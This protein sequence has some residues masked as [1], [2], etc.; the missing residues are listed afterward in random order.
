[1]VDRMNADETNQALEVGR[2]LARQLRERVIPEVDTYRIT[3]MAE[4][5]GNE[6]S[7]SLTKDN[8]Y[9]KIIEGTEALD[10][11][12]VP[13]DGRYLVVTPKTYRLM[14]ESSDVI[15]DESISKEERTRGVIGTLDGM[16]VIKV[17]S[18][19]FPAQAGFLIAHP[20]ATVSPIKLA[21]Y[22]V[23][24][25]PPGIS[26]WLVEGRIYYDAFILSNKEDAIFYQEDS[27]LPSV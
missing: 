23:H 1:M 7:A 25:N 16:T 26:G 5:A 10:N 6:D 24:D 27:S 13:S 3:Q 4:N 17:V 18:N 12:A 20:I 22:K 21:D 19:R 9:G 8:I 2:A 15:L 14:K 11:A